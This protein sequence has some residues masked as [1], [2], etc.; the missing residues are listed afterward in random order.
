MTGLIDWDNQRLNYWVRPSSVAIGAACPPA[1]KPTRYAKC[2]CRDYF[3]PALTLI[4]AAAWM[5]TDRL[6]QRDAR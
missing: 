3:Q 6:Q 2:H 1:R 4:R 5:P